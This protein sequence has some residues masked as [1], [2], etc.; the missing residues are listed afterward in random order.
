M[1]RRTTLVAT[2]IVALLQA[3]TAFGGGKKK[4]EKY[5]LLYVP[6]P[7]PLV[8]RM[9]QMAD[10]SEDDVVYDLGCGD[11]RVVITAAMRYN[12]E[13][14]GVDL[15]PERIK[16]SRRNAKRAEVTDQVTF[17]KQDLFDTYVGDADVV[18]LYL[19]PEI[20]EDLREKLLRELKPGTVVLSNDFGFGDWKPDMTRKY[21]GLG[22]AGDGLT[23]DEGEPMF[24]IKKAMLKR[25]RLEKALQTMSHSH[26]VLYWIV[27]AAV[28]GTWRWQSLDGSKRKRITAKLEQRFQT[29]K[30]WVR[31]GDGKKL[32]VKRGRISGREVYFDV[33]R[34]G[35]D[36]PTRFR[37][38][39]TFRSGTMTG[40][41]R[42]LGGSKPRQERWEAKRLSAKQRAPWK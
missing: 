26:R 33:K 9:L 7:E 6:T 8:T 39:G 1:G 22:N 15:D 11:G 38:H 35:S 2:V 40:T 18:F 37:F 25:G 21:G 10:V 14:V 4:G 5:D 29:L 31:F 30:G 3:G 32:S 27:P 24:D 41:I 12:A 28:E 19:L 36:Q 16:E 23:D 17:Q 34:K 13:G 42:R 20:M